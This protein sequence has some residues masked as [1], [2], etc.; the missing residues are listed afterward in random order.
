MD[1]NSSVSNIHYEF[2]VHIEQFSIQQIYDARNNGM[3]RFYCS[4]SI[5]RPLFTATNQLRFK[6]KNQ[7][8]SYVMNEL[9]DIT[10]VA[11]DKGIFLY[12][13]V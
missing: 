11:T 5:P 13:S 12:D 2:C 4:E 3:L 9:Y 1:S 6:F 10:Y 8:L 7:T